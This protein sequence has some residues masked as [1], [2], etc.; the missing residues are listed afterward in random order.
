MKITSI[1]PRL[2]KGMNGSIAQT[3]SVGDITMNTL[4]GQSLTL[5]NVLYV[6]DAKIRLIS[7]GKLGD[8][9]NYLSVFSKDQCRVY[10]QKKEEMLRGTRTSGGLY[11]IPTTSSAQ[12]YANLARAP[13]NLETWHKRLG[14]VSYQSI[15]AMAKKGMATGC[16]PTFPPYR[17]P[18]N[19]VSLVNR[20]RCLC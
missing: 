15:I 8:D 13:A 7:V 4:S 14:H 18:A 19:T 11:Y 3:I 17:Q 20:P 10:D 5:R 1:T 9:D 2:I 16:L 6:S 12:A